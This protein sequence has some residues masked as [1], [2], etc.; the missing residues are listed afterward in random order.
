VRTFSTSDQRS[1]GV[2]EAVVGVAMIVLKME[3][4]AGRTKATRHLLPY[5]GTTQIRF[6]EYFSVTGG[7]TSSKRHSRRNAAPGPAL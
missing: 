4:Q 6:K 7:D 2:R 1:T 5:A 3:T